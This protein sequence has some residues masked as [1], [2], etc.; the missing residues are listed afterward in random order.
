MKYDQLIKGKKVVACVLRST[1]YT[2]LRPSGHPIQPSLEEVFTKL[3][4]VMGNYRIDY[5]YLATEDY[6]IADAFKKEFSNR[7]IENKR[8]YYNE[9]YDSENLVMV[10][11]VHFDRDNDDYLKMLEYISSIN[12]VSKCDYLVTGLNGGSEM[13]IYRNGNQYKYVYVFDK[14]VY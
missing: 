1:D 14:G 6:Y 5:V 3:H 4:E 2:K 7:V 13:A 12:L 8:H 11:Q 9:Q 10:S